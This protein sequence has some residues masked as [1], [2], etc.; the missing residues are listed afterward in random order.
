MAQDVASV[1]MLTGNRPHDQKS[2]A[3]YNEFFTKAVRARSAWG[4]KAY[5]L[6][7]IYERLID[8]PDWRD[9]SKVAQYKSVVH[10][11]DND[12]TYR[13][14]QTAQCL[15]TRDSAIMYDVYIQK[16]RDLS[17]ENFANPDLK[18]SWE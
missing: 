7:K 12:E 16:C 9:P 10:R 17:A 11:W 4:R 5:D 13:E 6:K 8:V 14:R 15:W 1:Q 3:K 2:Q 18:F